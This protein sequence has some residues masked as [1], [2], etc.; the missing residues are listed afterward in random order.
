VSSQPFRIAVMNVD[1]TGLPQAA[2]INATKAES[3]SEYIAALAS[4]S[5]GGAPI[6]GEV[7]N[8]DTV[9]DCACVPLLFP[10]SVV[11]CCKGK[12]HSLSA[13]VLVDCNTTLLSCVMVAPV[14]V[15]VASQPALQRSLIDS[16]DIL[17]VLSS[18]T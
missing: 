2:C 4:A 18:N 8:V 14:L 17:R 6:S 3:E 1:S 15:N 10:M 13:G 12:N 11:F 9:A 5:P 16:K 7:F